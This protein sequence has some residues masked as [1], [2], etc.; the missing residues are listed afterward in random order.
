MKDV[1]FS[2][3]S[4]T[5]QTTRTPGVIKRDLP[6]EARVELGRDGPVFSFLCRPQCS[7]YVSQL[8]ALEL[9][10]DG[11]V[12]RAASGFMATGLNPTWIPL[13]MGED[14]I[15]VQIRRRRGCI[16]LRQGKAG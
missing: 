8:S 11:G 5:S 7:F 16:K 3:A 4:T 6:R 12:R 1:A 15:Y 2:E 13:Y 14:A 9:A 10:M